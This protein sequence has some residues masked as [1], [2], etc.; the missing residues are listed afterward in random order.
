MHGLPCNALTFGRRMFL[1]PTV[2]ISQ[3]IPDP[4]L[5]E[6]NTSTDG[7]LA[8][9]CPPGRRMCPGDRRKKCIPEYK[10]CDGVSDCKSGTDEDPEI[11]GQFLY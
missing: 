9:D 8:D 1:I 6:S 4:F 2:R 3:Q 10:F 5:T 7:V 11:C